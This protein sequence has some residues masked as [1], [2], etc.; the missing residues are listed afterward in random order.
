MVRF[1][2]RRVAQAAVTVLGVVTV[3]FFLVRLSGN[4]AALLLGAEATQADIDRLS[5]ALGFDK[6]LVEQYASF[7]GDVLRGDLGMS[8]RQG[9]PAAELVAQRLPA[10]FEL[11]LWAFAVGVGAAALTVLVIQ[12][13]GSRA[14]RTAV[15]WIASARQ[16]IP[17]FWLALMLVLVF[18]VTL[19]A[20]PALGRTSP[21]SLVL[22]MI[23]IATLEFALYVRLLDAGFLDQMSQDY[24]RTAQS[25]GQSHAVIVVRHVLPNAVLPVITVAGLNLGALLGGTIV[26][27]LVF[28]WPGLGQLIMS[29]ISARDYAVVQA[30]VLTIALFFIVTN[31]LVDLL[32]AVLDPRVR[33]R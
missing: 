17:S 5:A 19:G 26:V 31:L 18:S 15:L 22:P 32:Y 6:P 21:E 33:L 10:T 7:V 9:I 8:L 24:V 16:A 14:L 23:T 13:T 12:L 27:E 28:N 20:L 2:A 30:G 11:A 29:S 3:T 4:P 25:K 1:L